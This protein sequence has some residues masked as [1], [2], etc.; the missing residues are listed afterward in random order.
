[1]A[2]IYAFANLFSRVAAGYRQI[3]IVPLL[4]VDFNLL[5]RSRTFRT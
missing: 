2:V 5:L 3:K 1:V 4:C